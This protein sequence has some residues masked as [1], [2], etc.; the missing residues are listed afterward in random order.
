MTWGGAPSSQT[1]HLGVASTGEKELPLF[2]TQLA[3]KPTP[4]LQRCALRTHVHVLLRPAWLCGLH[5]PLSSTVT[6]PTT[7]TV[8]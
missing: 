2:E 5:G 4:D 8:T 1:T 7:S 3:G 6:D